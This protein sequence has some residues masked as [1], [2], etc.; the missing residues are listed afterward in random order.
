MYYECNE[1]GCDKKFSRI[2]DLKKHVNHIHKGFRKCV[3]CKK[4]FPDKAT[5]KIHMD[6]THEKH[7]CDQCDKK[8]MAIIH[9]KNHKKFIH[10]GGNKFP[11]DKCD[12]IYASS[13]LLKKHVLKTHEEDKSKI[14]WY[15]CDH[16]DKKYDIIS[17]LR[18]HVKSAH[19]GT[20]VEWILSVD[21]RYKLDGIL[22]F[23]KWSYDLNCSFYNR[24]WSDVPKSRQNYKNDRSSVKSKDLNSLF[25]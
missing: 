24:N 21:F 7:P 19:T 5:L 9:L 16:C 17:N 12:K 11:C 10:E 6:S 4:V 13:F 2:H 25:S 14:V 8:F 22:R 3:E 15:N 1:I 18:R 23:L 20:K